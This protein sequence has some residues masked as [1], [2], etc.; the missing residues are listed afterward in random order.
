MCLCLVADTVR[1][2]LLKQTQPS[3]EDK[4]VREFPTHSTYGRSSVE[5][6]YESGDESIDA[7]DSGLEDSGEEPA[8]R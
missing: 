7:E 5:D 2:A 4:L 3:R 6:D 1:N 8:K